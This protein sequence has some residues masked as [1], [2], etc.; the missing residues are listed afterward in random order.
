M[1]TFGMPGSRRSLHCRS[2]QDVRPPASPRVPGVSQHA[3]DGLAQ[4][5]ERKGSLPGWPQLKPL[6]TG[7]TQP[8][9]C[10]CDALEAQVTLGP[11]E[12]EPRHRGT[13]DPGRAGKSCAGCLRLNLEHV[14]ALLTRSGQPLAAQVAGAGLP[15]PVKSAG[16]ASPVRQ[17]STPGHQQR[18]ATPAPGRCVK[19]RVQQI[20]CRVRA[21]RPALRRPW[22]HPREVRRLRRA[23]PSAAPLPEL[24]QRDV[25][26]LAADQPHCPRSAQS[27][28]IPDDQARAGGHGGSLPDLVLGHH[29]AALG[30]TRTSPLCRARILPLAVGWMVADREN[31]R[32][33][34]GVS[35]RRWTCRANPWAFRVPTGAHPA[36]RSARRIRVR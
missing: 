25:R 20:P 30:P 8:A 12:H 16:R 15:W 19:E 28:G 27:R 33:S 3:S 2:E 36:L 1:R 14:N 6:E 11:V 13:S 31:S 10:R 4:G 23:A 5:V 34:A 17:R 7:R 9:G 22:R 35:C 29:Q 26:I 32:R 18:S 24:R 21:R